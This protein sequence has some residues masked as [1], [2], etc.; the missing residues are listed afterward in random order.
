MTC[1]IVT[2]MKYGLD[3]RLDLQETFGKKQTKQMKPTTIEKL[4]A[5]LGCFGTF[6]LLVAIIGLFISY[7]VMLLWNA[8]IVGFIPGVVAI[9]HWYHAFGIIILCSILFKK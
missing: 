4:I 2:L 7:P 1:L 9:Q 8:C 3:L 5:G 6:L